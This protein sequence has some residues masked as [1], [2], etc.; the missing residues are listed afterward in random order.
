M[1]LFG[2]I[3]ALVLAGSIAAAAGA[4][5]GGGSPNLRHGAL[6]LTKDCTG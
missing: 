5:G 4:R 2:L 6:H 1:R 3:L